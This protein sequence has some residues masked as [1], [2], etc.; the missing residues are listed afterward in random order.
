MH[1]IPS[2]IIINSLK[3]NPLPPLLQIASQTK[4][5]H[6]VNVSCPSASIRYLPLV[7]DRPLVDASLNYLYTHISHVSMARAF[8]LHPEMPRVLKLLVNVL[9][10]EQP[11][12]QEKVTLDVTGS[13]Q[14]VPS[15]HL[16]TRNHELTK[17]ELDALIELPEPQRCYDWYDANHVRCKTD[18]V[19]TQVDFWNLYKDTFTPYID[20]IPCSWPQAMVLQDPVQRFVVQG[21]DRRKDSLVTD[22][23]HCIWDRFQCSTSPFA[24]TSELYDHVLQHLVDAEATELPCLWGS[25][26]ITL[27]AGSH[28]PM[29]TPTTRP[30]PPPRNT[31]ITYEKPNADP[32]H[33][34]LTALLVLR[35]LFR[36]SFAS[37]D[38][39]PRADAE[40]YGFPGIDDVRDQSSE[41]EGERR[42]R[43]AFVGVRH[44]VLMGWVTEMIDAV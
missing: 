33:T 11:S 30:P 16:S 39:A 44:E 31:V 17:E 23:F 43:R 40:H 6:Y 42:G 10:A 7:V 1:T 28:Y 25:S 13:I 9:I 27:S 4:D 32:S 20:N 14:T 2:K 19:V 8:L 22:R 34:S 18:G 3:P 38:A 41:R 36:T 24:S 15:G 37:A 5:R 21:V 26:T 35:I 29:E 12:L